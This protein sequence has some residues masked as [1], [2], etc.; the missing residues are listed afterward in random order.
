MEADG[1]VLHA[2]GEEG[3]AAGGVGDGLQHV[4]A[5]VLA[6]AGVGADGIDDGLGA[7]AHLDGVGLERAAVVVVAVRDQDDGLAHVIGLLQGQHLV[8]AGL[9]ERVIERGAA[10]GTQ[11]LNAGIQQVDAIGEVLRDVGLHVKAFHEGAVVGVQH[12]EQE[13]GG[14]LLLK[15]EALADGAGGVHHDADAQRQVGLLLEAADGLRRAAVVQ[16][17]E[18]LL[19][20]AGDEV[21]VLVGDRE[22]QVDLAGEDGDPRLGRWRAFAGLQLVRRVGVAGG[23]RSGLRRGRGGG[24]ARC[25]RWRLGGRLGRGLAAGR[26]HGGRDDQREQY[27]SRVAADSHKHYRT[28]LHGL[29]AFAGPRSCSRNCCNS[30]GSGARRSSFSP[31]RGC[32]NSSSAAWRKLRS[33]SRLSSWTRGEPLGEAAAGIRR[34]AP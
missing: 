21:A 14:S 25:L 7:L 10:A 22:D 3:L 26:M 18:V 17:A 9:V 34:G 23:G 15:L 13:V 4:V 33:S 30:A 20:Q 31:E 1:D 12:L 28:N 5:L 8:A 27:P 11:L 29:L 2:G 16:Q 24:L 19:L 6:G 32:V